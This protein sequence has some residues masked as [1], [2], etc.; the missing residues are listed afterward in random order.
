MIISTHLPKTAG[1]SFAAS[2]REYFGEDHFIS[3]YNDW[4]INTPR[5]KRNFNAL[6]NNIIL[7]RKDYS[8][9][10]CIHGHF[11]PLKY[12]GLRKRKSLSFI[13]WMRHPVQRMASH[14]YFW[15]RTYDP[16]KS[17]ILQRK[18]VEEEWTLERFCLGPEA[19]NFYHVFLWGFP[20]K[21]FDFIGITE[22]YEEDF[23]WFAEHFLNAPLKFKADNVNQNIGKQ[24]HFD[25]SLLK[26][27]EHW[28]KK[29]I[30]LYEQAVKIR[31]NRMALQPD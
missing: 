1:S 12:L 4:P 24:Y 26:K 3:D 17:P 15:K 7:R 8:A 6:R 13:A 11:L 28:H 22:F 29:D 30:A 19:R 23:N 10:E 25:A 9:I 31:N 16:I 14:Y 27:I 18:M 2:L 21:Q 5:L 20:L